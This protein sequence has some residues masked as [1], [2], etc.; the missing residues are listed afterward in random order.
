MPFGTPNIA[1]AQYLHMHNIAYSISRHLSTESAE[2][3]ST[4]TFSLNQYLLFSQAKCICGIFTFAISY[5]I[6]MRIYAGLLECISK[7][8]FGR[9]IGCILSNVVDAIHEIAVTLATRIRNLF[10]PP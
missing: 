3:C 8:Y 4:A 6:E 7:G 1:T 5:R 9:G 10:G 2:L